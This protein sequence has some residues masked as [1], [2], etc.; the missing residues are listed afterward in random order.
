MK[1]LK[2]QKHYGRPEVR[3]QKI[4]TIIN[5]HRLM[6][7]TE[8]ESKEELKK[9]EARKAINLTCYNDC[10]KFVLSERNLEDYSKFT[11][12]TPKKDF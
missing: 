9:L 6:H 8:Q 1:G 5:A 11:G 4:F 2:T 10:L 3:A 7:L 12:D